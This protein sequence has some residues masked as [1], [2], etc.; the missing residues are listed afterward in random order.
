MSTAQPT[1]DD[2]WRMFQET[3]RKFKEVTKAI[4]KLG[5]RLGRFYR[6]CAVRLFQERGILVHVVHQNVSAQR[7]TEGIEVDLLVVGRIPDFPSLGS[8]KTGFQ[9]YGSRILRTWGVAP[10]W[11]CV[12]ALP[13]L[14]RLALPPFHPAHLY[15][16]IY[17]ASTRCGATMRKAPKARLYTSLGQRPRSPDQS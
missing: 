10:G 7:G 11:Y 12:G 6:G 8:N 5:N 14:L 17:P 2:V 13:L 16:K 1:F 15:R 4:G 3:N 9:P